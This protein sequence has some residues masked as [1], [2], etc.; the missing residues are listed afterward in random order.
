[1]TA[2]VNPDTDIA[3][4]YIS[5][6]ALDSDI[7]G[8]LM[9]GRQAV[10]LSH[11]G[12]LEDYLNGHRFDPETGEK[13]S[14]DDLETLAQEFG[15]DYQDDEPIVE[16]VYEGVSYCSSW[17]GGALNFFIF[18]SLFTT[19]T[20]RRASPCVPNCGILDTLDGSEF[21]YDVPPDWRYQP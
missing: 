19:D 8:E 13:T 21:S 2:N 14:E 17:L 16:G 11:K 10:N 18:H 7:V 12:A 15:E 4:G 1:M 3:Y 9:Y 5:A 20:A 6:S